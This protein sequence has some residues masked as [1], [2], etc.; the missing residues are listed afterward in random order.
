[1]GRKHNVSIDMLRTDPLAPLPTMNAVITSREIDTS[2][3]DT[4]SLHAKWTAGPVGTFDVQ[5][6][7]SEKDDWYSL[8]FGT[9]LAV[10]TGDDEAQFVLSSMPFIRIRIIYT[11][12]SG[13][14]PLSLYANAKTVGA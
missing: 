1:M 10:L 4:A 7:N 13:N 11:P 2:E 6:K 9:P 5:A 8:N 3:M 14:S 12:T